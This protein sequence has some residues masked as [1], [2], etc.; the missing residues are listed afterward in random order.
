MK[1][2]FTY[3]KRDPSKNV[4]QL[5]TKKLAKLKK[6]FRGNVIAEV[7]IKAS[8][9]SHAMSMLVNSARNNY[10]VSSVNGDM[11]KNIDVCI[12]KL[13]AQV[14]KAKMEYRTDSKKINEKVAFSNRYNLEPVEEVEAE[15]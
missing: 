11:Y 7:N 10:N 13:K 14:K 4:E 12:N 3:S 8:G 9:K 2:K 1:I 6:Y 5:I 15:L